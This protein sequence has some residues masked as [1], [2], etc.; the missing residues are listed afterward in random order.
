MPTNKAGRTVTAILL[1]LAVIAPA[2]LVLLISYSLS[3]NQT[4]SSTLFFG[5]F[6]AD[7][8]GAFWWMSQHTL[9]AGRNA[10]MSIHQ[11]IA[12]MKMHPELLPP[13]MTEFDLECF[14]K[15]QRRSAQARRDAW[16]AQFRGAAKS[17]R[18]SSQPR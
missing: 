5:T 11:F 8:C 7:L 13:G 9:P 6:L 4:I 14:R 15:L 16:L 1:A 12:H 10:R 2:S 3:G 17:A 18:P